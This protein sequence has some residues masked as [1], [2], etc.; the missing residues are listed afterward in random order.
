MLVRANGDP[1]AM[2]PSVRKQITGVN[3]SQGVWG[4][5]RGNVL[6][7]AV[8]SGALGVIIGIGIGLRGS[9]ALS[10][11]IGQLVSGETGDLRV[12]LSVLQ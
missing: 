3:A 11:L 6:G 12:V 9:L 4:A 5:Q 2:L 1:L 8:R 10:R 7:L